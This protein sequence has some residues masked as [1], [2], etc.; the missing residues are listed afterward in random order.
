MAILTGTARN[1][2]AGFSESNAM[3]AS[4]GTKGIT[5]GVLGFFESL[6][7]HADQFQP[8]FTEDGFY[9]SPA[10][11]A[12]GVR[13][14]SEKIPSQRRHITQ[15]PKA[16]VFIKKKQ[17][18]SLASNNELRM[19][20]E[21]EKLYLRCVKALFRR[22]CEEMAFHESLVNISSIY[23]TSGFLLTDD[24]LDSSLDYV[25]NVVGSLSGA[26]D[27]ISSIGSSSF[28]GS[29]MGFEDRFLSFMQGLYRAKQRSQRS[30]A[31][32]FT[33]WVDDPA[34]PDYAGLGP[35][36][37][38]IELNMVSSL[39]SSCGLNDGSSSLEIE[40]PYQLMLIT[41]ADIENALYIAT[42][43]SYQISRFYD[44][45]A[46]FRLAIA[47]NADRRLNFLR[48]KRGEKEIS[49][50][51]V[52][53]DTG[54]MQP[55]ATLGYVDA[56]KLKYYQWVGGIL[57]A[58]DKEEATGVGLN[59]EDIVLVNQIV[60]NLRQYRDATT[61]PPAQPGLNASESDLRRLSKLR[62]KMRRDFLGQHVIQPMDQITLFANSNTYDVTPVGGIVDVLSG[63]SARLTDTLDPQLIEQERADILGS[64]SGTDPLS[65]ANDLGLA[66]LYNS[67]RKKNI[68]RDDGA[69]I[70]SGLAEQISD[71]Y[72]SSGGTFKV[73]VSCQSNLQYLQVSRYTFKPD[74]N[75][76]LGAVNDPLTP[77][78]LD[79]A[80]DPASGLIIADKFE[81]SDKNK[82]RLDFLRIAS[83]PLVSKKLRGIDDILSDKR[84]GLAIISHTPGL[85]YK[86]K[87]GI[88]SVAL[89][90]P[91]GGGNPGG[92]SSLRQPFAKLDAANIAS[93]LITG[94]P[95]DYAT[96]LEGVSKV[97]GTSSNPTNLARDFFNYLFEYT[98]RV[99]KYYGN[100]IPAKDR[101][102][103]KD[104]V[105]AYY[106]AKNALTALNTRANRL[107][108]KLNE[109]SRQQKVGQ[110]T[111]T[112]QQKLQDEIIRISSEISELQTKALPSGVQLS[113]EGNNAF[114]SVD[115]IDRVQADREILYKTKRKPEDV[116]F[117][118]DKNYFIVSSDYDTEFIIQAF[119]ASLGNFSMYDAEYSS[120]LETI[121]AAVSALQLE[122]FA[123]PDGNLVLRPPRYNR[124]PLSLM[125]DMIRRM[126]PGQGS[127]LPA[128]V[129]NVLASRTNSL[130][131]AIF[132][133]E[134]NIAKD[135]YSI[136]L[137]ESEV[138]GNE[139]SVFPFITRSSGNASGAVSSPFQLN[140]TAVISEMERV[141]SPGTGGSITS[142]FVFGPASRVKTI[143]R[144]VA[145]KENENADVQQ[146]LTDVIIAIRSLAGESVSDVL[147]SK[148]ETEAKAA[149]AKLKLDNI[150][151]LVAA[152]LTSISGHLN[153]RRTLLRSL[154]D[155]IKRESAGAVSPL[156]QVGASA[157]AAMGTDFQSAIGIF[158]SM[159]G[160]SL[161]PV[162]EN[163]VENDLTNT[164]GPGSAKR[165]IIN[166][167][168]VISG[169]FSHRPP[170]Y[171]QVSVT[172]ALDF[173]SPE[174]SGTIGEL[175]ALTAVATDFDSWRQYGFRDNSPIRRPDMTSAETQCA[176]YASL[177]LATQRK[178]IHSGRITVIGNEYYRPGDNV[179]LSYRNMIYYV[180]NVS[181]NL[182]LNDGSFTTEL[183]LAYGRPPGEIIPTPLDIIGAAPSGAS[184]LTK[185]YRMA[186]SQDRASTQTAKGPTILNLGT[187]HISPAL[188][189]RVGTTRPTELMSTIVKANGSELDNVVLKARAR[190]LASPTQAGKSAKIEVRGYYISA[191]GD[192]QKSAVDTCSGMISRL[193]AER[194]SGGGAPPVSKT[195]DDGSR[196]TGQA[197]ATSSPGA[198]SP[199][200]V[201]HRVI[202]ISADFSDEERL[203][204]PFPS[205]DAWLSASPVKVSETKT[206][207][208]PVNAF[209]IVF[210][211]T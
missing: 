125:L 142:S 79:A 177:M 69:C 49:F 148:A 129:R 83:G 178:K 67:I 73:S 62:D 29:Q 85:A 172:G 44:A 3:G 93:I 82:E 157:L 18:G 26:S 13:P 66:A 211:I 108:T 103:D 8:S 14:T 77:F 182:S 32:A 76:T 15:R 112:D 205:E 118:K 199:I 86:W 24:L 161:P 159:S 120:P 16:T 123:D 65:F 57:S 64:N 52:E 115:A 105:M 27:I 30:R 127:M 210:V 176:P 94:Q 54:E 130:K 17:F 169:S 58:D 166:D 104:S 98:D 38:T 46:S 34:E 126:P 61:I 195:T 134:L 7:Q 202:D 88:I 171:N 175:P 80:V 158:G 208:L 47:Q 23:E 95:Y 39:S 63:A 99:K 10:I 92:I 140:E 191:E 185:K 146:R 167:A 156:E 41:A 116:R 19:L 170:E 45:T 42:S 204:M 50:E 107:I 194:L 183:D 184:F 174:A 197:Q 111:S 160:A 121:R 189:Q 137:S 113:L 149:L 196:S 74:L 84:N 150:R 203:Q 102:L 9:E 22:K 164:D 143:D 124:T 40:D 201:S 55:T 31:S 207:D 192:V 5:D 128:F 206:I 106:Q 139:G 101:T 81:L 87:E 51:F 188:R 4:D 6:A 147:V 145:N 173:I 75:N 78:N 152:K 91:G 90:A 71:R 165:F 180:T 20:D 132:K 96:F 110:G 12:P 144:V 131:D 155:T 36:T 198:N 97:S 153:D 11:V 154:Y 179:Y 33:R 187:F 37:G 28:L 89:D 25:I 48:Q 181:H 1:R 136:G 21:D 138:S 100:F 59:A 56:A 135:L 141:F 70:F 190:V 68:F 2:F 117:N 60:S 163:L 109:L 133:N 162:L 209:D 119:A 35:G 122:F 43:R 151:G 168:V 114:L 53:N 193:I 200:A 186:N 72:D